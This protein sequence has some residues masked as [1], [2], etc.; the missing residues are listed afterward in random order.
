MASDALVMPSRTGWPLA[1][2]PPAASARVVR[3]REVEAVDE[4]AR[5]E[6][7]VARLGDRDLAQHLA[8]DDLDVLV[9]DVDALAAVDV[10][11]LLDDVAKR[12]VR[13][14]EVRAGRAG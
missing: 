6:V 2:S 1:G 14:L 9:V 4:L 10:L 11:D 5:Q 13:A 7:G 3:R 12:L 8:S